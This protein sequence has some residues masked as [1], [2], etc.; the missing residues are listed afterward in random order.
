M[1]GKRYEPKDILELDGIPA[2]EVLEMLDGEEIT[3]DGNVIIKLEKR[4]P[5]N[6]IWAN[7]YLAENPEMSRNFFVDYFNNLSFYGQIDRILKDFKNDPNPGFFYNLKRG[8][9]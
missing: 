1:I 7:V 5:W 6:S 2:E 9:L 4:V 8:K 3:R